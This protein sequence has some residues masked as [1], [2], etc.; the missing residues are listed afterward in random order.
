MPKEL[1]FILE[2]E[3]GLRI[4]EIVTEPPLKHVQ[5]VVMIVSILTWREETVM[6]R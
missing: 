2:G 4:K 6:N 5:V 3:Q 1:L